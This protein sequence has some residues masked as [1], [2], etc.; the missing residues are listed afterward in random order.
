MAYTLDIH[1]KDNDRAFPI[2][3]EGFALN[4][5]VGAKGKHATQSL[6]CKI[7]SREASLLF[8]QSKDDIIRA[9]V[10]N[11]S[12]TVF[13]GV[14]RPYRSFSAR[15]N[16]EDALSL[17]I[18]D[19]TEVLHA[20]AQ[21][22]EAF[23]A[24]SVEHV[25]RAVYGKVAGLPEMIEFPSELSE[26]QVDYCK[27]K[28]GT[29]YD[30]W[31]SEML[32]EFG[33]DFRFK[34]GKCV[35]FSTHAS[36]SAQSIDDIR[37]TLTV[38]RSDDRNDGIRVK[39]GKFPEKRMQILDHRSPVFADKIPWNGLSVAVPHSGYYH[40][41]EMDKDFPA[42]NNWLNWDPKGCSASDMVK[43]SNIRWK[44]WVDEPWAGITV[45]PS[46]N[47]YLR[48]EDNPAYDLQ[49]SAVSVAYNRVFKTGKWSGGHQFCITAEAD[50]RYREENAQETYTDG[51]SPKVIN[52]EFITTE[53]DSEAFAKRE[54]SRISHAAVTYAF[55]SLTYYEPGCF[56]NLSDEVTGIQSLVRIVSCN[57]DA[58]GIFTVKAEGAGDA[59]A[60]VDIKTMR[61][62]D[63]SD[64][65]SLFIRLDAD[66]TEIATGETVK[67]EV[68]GSI[69]DMQQ[70][71]GFTYKWY[72]NEVEIPGQTGL[73][74]E[75][76]ESELMKGDNVIACASLYNGEEH[77]SASVK[78]HDSVPS[79]TD[80]EFA[81]SD[82]MV[83]PSATLKWGEDDILWEAVN[84]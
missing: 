7:R 57:M 73:T 81:L 32:Y 40:S 21:A 20:Y 4:D 26:K 43:I 25:F 39:Y 8:L 30:S 24:K 13:E 38:S 11:G 17:Q 84:G 49:G 79:F 67:V 42:E 29:Y 3:R 80:V 34:V 19:Y 66:R 77:A 65:A 83:E 76:A 41:Y 28:K 2:L 64:Q 37:R 82:S 78:V 35:I 68:S 71:Y 45:A 54:I 58:D 1:F 61:L 6:S 33:Y 69:L 31:L 9:E 59:G 56:Y 46:K 15:G 51:D 62:K 10:K 18:M 22:D 74:L 75:L 70:E 48:I 23:L 63:A 16:F 60:S 53:E 52:A 72:L 44:V 14:V 5:L 12:E 47:S 27:L 36:S 55:T 50:V